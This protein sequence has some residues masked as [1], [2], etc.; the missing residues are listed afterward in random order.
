[1]KISKI[2]SAFSIASG[3]SELLKHKNEIEICFSKKTIEEILHTLESYNNEWC[4]QTAK[5]IKS[6]SPTSLKVTLRALLEGE[7]LDFDACMKMEYQ[8]TC[9]L[10][11]GHDFY[12]GVRAAIIDKDQSPR[13][14]PARLEDVNL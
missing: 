11:Q 8:L 7:Q 4:L 6:K 10:L 1:M 2:I 14:K 5:I 13:W 9:H 12:E 3:P